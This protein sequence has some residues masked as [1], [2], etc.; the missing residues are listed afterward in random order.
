MTTDSGLSA[1]QAARQLGVAVTTI[2]TWDRRYGL[3]PEQ[4]EQGRHRRYAPR[5][6]QRLELMARLVA[7]GVPTAEA[8]R[9]ARSAAQPERLTEPAGRLAEL[10]PREVPES[11]ASPLVR[12]L[13]RAALALNDAQLDRILGEAVSADV[14]AAWTRLICPV[15]RDIGR[16]HARTG[17]YVEIERLLTREVSAALALTRRPDG[18]TGLLLACTAEEQHTLP[19]EALAASLAARGV[20]SR[21]LGARVPAAALA[22]ATARTGPRAVVLWAHTPATASSAQLLAISTARP[23]PALVA[24]AGPGWLERDRPAGVHYLADFDAALDLLTEVAQPSGVR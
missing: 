17:R 16:R 12:G 1:G 13:R 15:L 22:A 24:A 19:L 4:R 23:R 21:M 9:C 5:D 11:A 6:M 10:S 14:A 20:R 2:R 7:D 8:A 3:G 18:P